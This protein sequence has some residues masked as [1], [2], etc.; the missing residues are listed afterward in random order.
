MTEQTKA[1]SSRPQWDGQQTIVQFLKFT[2]VS[3]YLFMYDGKKAKLSKCTMRALYTDCGADD[4]AQL[5]RSSLVASLLLL[6]FLATAP[7]F[8]VLVRFLR[9]GPL[10]H[11][12]GSHLR[13]RV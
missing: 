12:R 6:R 13:L 9:M 2:Y 11:L 4:L 3:F 8:T 10:S 1:Y 5:L 7:R